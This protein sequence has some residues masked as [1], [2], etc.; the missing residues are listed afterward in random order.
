MTEPQQDDEKPHMTRQIHIDSGIYGPELF[1]NAHQLLSGY[2]KGPKAFQKAL[3]ERKPIPRKTPISSEAK[4]QPSQLA[5][6]L[7]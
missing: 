6:P 7:P 1:E 5:T 4:S 3:A 2:L